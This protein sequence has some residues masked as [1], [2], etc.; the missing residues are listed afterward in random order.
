MRIVSQICGDL[1]IRKNLEELSQLVDE[2]I[3]KRT[4]IGVF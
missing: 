3:K 2:I 4:D 1:F